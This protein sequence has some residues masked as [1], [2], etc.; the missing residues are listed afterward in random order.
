MAQLAVTNGQCAVRSAASDSE[1][2]NRNNCKLNGGR[3]MGRGWMKV[4]V[5]GGGGGE[6]ER[7]TLERGS[8]RHFSRIL[9]SLF[10]GV[11]SDV[12]S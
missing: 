12:S 1:I 2:E 4:C 7:Q 8:F 5:C 9:G 11:F 6:K 3:G 10:S